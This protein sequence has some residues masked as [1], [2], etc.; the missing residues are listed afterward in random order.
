M[1]D[2]EFTKHFELT[3]KAGE[4]DELS[5]GQFEGHAAVFSNIDL[6]GDKIARN[7]FVNT[8]NESKGR[9]PILMGHRTDVIVGFS[10][11]AVEDF[12]G[13]L[14][15]GELTLDSTAGRDAHAVMKHA[16]SVGQ[17]MGLSIGYKIRDNGAEVDERTCVR[18]LKDLDVFEF[19]IAAV[20]ANMRARVSRV[21][22]GSGEGGEWTE[23]DFEQ[24][25]RDSG[26]PKEAVLRFIAGGYRALKSDR[27]D[28][29][30][31]LSDESRA[32]AREWLADLRRKS[33]VFQ[34]QR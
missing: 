6:Q 21:K 9:W 30:T 15:R 5:D 31:E 3:L 32:A 11:S 13:L 7:A 18:L 26:L 33:I 14:V 4:D 29:G 22:S 10:T 8:I 19:S 2:I 20:P 17:K 25:L 28:T 16:Q 23:R 1:G 27:R 34:M 12:K 24:H